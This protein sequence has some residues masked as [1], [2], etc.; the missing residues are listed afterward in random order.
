MHFSVYILIFQILSMHFLPL[1]VFR[2]V[3]FV[4]KQHRD[5]FDPRALKC[6]FLRYSNTQKGGLILHLSSVS[7][8]G[9]PILKKG[10]KC[11]YL[12]SRKFYISMHVTFLEIQPILCLLSQLS[13]GGD[14]WWFSSIKSKPILVAFVF[15]SFVCIL[16][17]WIK[18]H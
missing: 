16:F 14:F 13:S 1:K 15:D 7:S 17:F 18:R 11:Y 5:K 12:L 8:Q 6:I 9:V 2:R 4:H 10:Y 3:S